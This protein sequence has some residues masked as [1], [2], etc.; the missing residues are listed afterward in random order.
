MKYVIVT[1]AYGGMGY[2]AVK[3]LRDSGYFVFAL[4]IPERKNTVINKKTCF[5]LV[6]NRNVFK[7]HMYSVGSYKK[8]IIKA[9]S[10]GIRRQRRTTDP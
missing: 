2:A 5:S 6:L 4:E 8:S 10:G 7:Y 9:F 1:G 3:A